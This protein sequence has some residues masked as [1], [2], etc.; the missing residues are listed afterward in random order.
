[1]TQSCADRKFYQGPLKVKFSSRSSEGGWFQSWLYRKTMSRVRR[2]CKRMP[3]P[4]CNSQIV[5]A[6]VTCAADRLCN[7]LWFR[8]DSCSSRPFVCLSRWLPA[9]LPAGLSLC[10]L[11]SMMR[12][13]ESSSLI[14]VI[15][16][17]L[18][19]VELSL[20]LSIKCKKKTLYKHIELY[21]S[22]KYKY[23][24]QVDLYCFC[25]SDLRTVF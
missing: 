7:R 20:S 25:F 12:L 1:M 18:L 13:P 6:A 21:C 19:E 9:C 10:S 4:G 14:Q 23:V 8:Y 3:S 22:K 5:P 2:A 17:C 15:L 24:L 11:R 16:I